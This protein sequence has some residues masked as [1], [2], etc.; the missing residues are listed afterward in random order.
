MSGL[1][2]NK[3]KICRQTDPKSSG[4]PKPD[5]ACSSRLDSVEPKRRTGTNTTMEADGSHHITTGI[6]VSSP[7][8][9][10]L[11]QEGVNR[12]HCI[13]PGNTETSFDRIGP[14]KRRRKRRNE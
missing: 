2:Q 12:L 8:L 6:P 3:T 11:F 14:G 7:K 9:K 13:S 4:S 5:F 10:A 1:P